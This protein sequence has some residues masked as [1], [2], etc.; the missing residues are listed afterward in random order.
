MFGDYSSSLDD[1]NDSSSD[2]NINSNRSTANGHH[3]SKKGHQG[4]VKATPERT[5]V[6]L[7]NDSND[8]ERLVPNPFGIDETM[9]PK[10]KQTERPELTRGQMRKTYGTGFKLL[11][12]M[13]FKS[14]KGMGKEE[15]G[16]INPVQAVVR[17]AKV[18]LQEYE[19]Q[20]KATVDDLEK[21]LHR[22]LGVDDTSDPEIIANGSDAIASGYNASWIRGNRTQRVAYKSKDN[23]LKEMQ[24]LFTTNVEDTDRQQQ[25]KGIRLI[26]M[27]KAGGPIELDSRMI[28]KGVIDS[29]DTKLKS[30]PPLSQL[31]YHV[32]DA[33]VC[34]E[35]FIM[36]CHR[37]RSD[38]LLN[39]SRAEIEKSDLTKKAGDLQAKCEAQEKLAQD[40]LLIVKNNKDILGEF[41]NTMMTPNFQNTVKTIASD[42]EMDTEIEEELSSNA[43]PSSKKID[44][45]RENV[46]ILE[47]DHRIALASVDGDILF[48]SILTAIIENLEP[49]YFI[50]ESVRDSLLEWQNIVSDR[51]W[52]RVIIRTLFTKLRIFL[53]EVNTIPPWIDFSPIVAIR[54]CWIPEPINMN[55]AAELFS[56]D[57]WPRWLNDFETWLTSGPSPGEV[58]RIYQEWR[59]HMPTDVVESTALGR[60]FHA[61]GLCCIRRRFEPMH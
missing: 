38:K 5:P 13:G 25:S 57:L 40:T 20:P 19:N 54:Q 46:K 31:L 53:K 59:C 22:G 9:E 56:K 26:D 55:I 58:L 29:M 3:E 41:S 11:Q 32:E 8:Q 18:G 4:F 33:L 37:A 48:G 17:K 49:Q 28:G 6:A 24:Q 23:L 61:K 14:G 39:K 42:D 36:D 2:D 52:N 34:M 47:E 51:I 10:P 45:C 16:R 12:K 60:E 35:A 43:N 1:G 15:N 44:R 50:D 7:N 30:G 21:E 27:T